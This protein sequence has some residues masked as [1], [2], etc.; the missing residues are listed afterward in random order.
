MRCTSCWAKFRARAAQAPRLDKLLRKAPPSVRRELS[1]PL[2]KQ[3][4]IFQVL[5][6]APESFVGDLRSPER[7]RVA[8]SE[9]GALMEKAVQLGLSSGQ[10]DDESKR[11]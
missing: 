6:F 5:S 10:A 4:D 1:V 11:V 7:L 9:M 8:V 3:M 2:A